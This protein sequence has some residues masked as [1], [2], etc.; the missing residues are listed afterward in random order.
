M[1][2]AVCTTGAACLVLSKLFYLDSSFAM[3]VISE[4]I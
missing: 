2:S 3:R 4:E 1:G